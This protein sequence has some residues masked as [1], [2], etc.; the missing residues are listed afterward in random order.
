MIKAIKV[1]KNVNVA[2]CIKAVEKGGIN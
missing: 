2:V 1:N